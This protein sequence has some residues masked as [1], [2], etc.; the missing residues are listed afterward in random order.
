MLYVD[1]SVAVNNLLLFNHLLRKEFKLQEAAMAASK[2]ISYHVPAMYST[3]NDM[4]RARDTRGKEYKCTLTFDMKTS[5]VEPTS[6]CW[7]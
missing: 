6:W 2:I 7:A 3:G 1:E 4:G 5:C